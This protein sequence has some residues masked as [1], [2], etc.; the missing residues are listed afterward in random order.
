MSKTLFTAGCLSLFTT[1]VHVFL[2]GPEIHEP[3]LASDAPELV[4]A[5]GSVIWH[6]I[7]A[8]LF[9]NSL[10]LF[11]A[12]RNSFAARPLA[13]LVCVQYFAFAALFIGYG[14]ARFGS[15]FI[16]QQWI[17]FLV[18]SLLALWSM[19]HSPPAKSNETLAARA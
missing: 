16:M 15:V 1:A 19:T 18:M 3:L 17:G 4:R 14:L 7:S 8:M 10:A 5:V 13:A 6:A 12:A 2:G 9:L 11:Y